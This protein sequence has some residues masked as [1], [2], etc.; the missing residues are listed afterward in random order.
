MVTATCD[1]SPPLPACVA[2]VSPLLLHNGHL[3]L[4]LSCLLLLLFCV[5][6]CVHYLLVRKEARM[7]RLA[8]LSNTHS[9][10]ESERAET[11]TGPIP[12][13]AKQAVPDR[14]ASSVDATAAPPEGQ[15]N[16]ET[17]EVYPDYET[18]ASSLAL[19][20][21]VRNL[22]LHLGEIEVIGI[23]A[24]LPNGETGTPVFTS[25]NIDALMD[26][27]NLIGKLPQE[28]IQAQL[29][30]NVVQAA[31][32]QSVRGVVHYVHC[33]L[34]YA[35]CNP[36]TVA[37]SLHSVGCGVISTL[38]RCQVDLSVSVACRG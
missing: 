14:P 28:A 22:G 12:T 20:Q 3:F 21:R 4:P 34:W 11:K 35:V 5:A 15:R 10:H 38:W 37:L 19:A 9:A 32:V 8:S 24:G 7:M 25:N 1:P 26:G 33:W 29:D 23:S 27:K 6:L 17:G 31:V 16:E 30:R 36:L 13:L 2:P 18:L